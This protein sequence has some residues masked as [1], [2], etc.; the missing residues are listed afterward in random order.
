[1]NFIKSEFLFLFYTKNKENN[2]IIS[3]KPLLILNTDG[4]YTLNH[5]RDIDFQSIVEENEEIELGVIRIPKQ[6]ASNI[7]NKIISSKSFNH[8]HVFILFSTNYK[9][10]IKN[11]RTFLQESTRGDDLI[12]IPNHNFKLE[13]S[14]MQY[15]DID[16]VRKIK[17]GHDKNYILCIPHIYIDNHFNDEFKKLF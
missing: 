12:K 1:M 8:S 2:F 10:H 11:K 14:Y 4:N 6:G 15:K 16:L 7:I 3:N 13:V 5:L 9:V 17:K